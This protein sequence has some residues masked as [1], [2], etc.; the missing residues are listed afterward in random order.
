MFCFALHCVH[1]SFAT[2]LMGKR[3]VV[4]SLFFVFLGCLVIVVWLFLTVRGVCLQFVNVIFPDH[5][6]Y[7][8]GSWDIG[9]PRLLARL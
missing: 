8:L 2:I 6:H 3:E 4:A 7:V 9:T 5:T 1:S